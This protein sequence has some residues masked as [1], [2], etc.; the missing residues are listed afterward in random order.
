MGCSH[1]ICSRIYT[2]KKYT[3]NEWYSNCSPVPVGVLLYSYLHSKHPRY[4]IYALFCK[5]RS[6]IPGKSVQDEFEVHFY[7]RVQDGRIARSHK[8]NVNFHIHCDVSVGHRHLKKRGIYLRERNETSEL[9]KVGSMC[10]RFLPKIN[11]TS[12]IEDGSSCSEIYSKW[13]R[14]KFRSF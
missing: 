14:S 10:L 13:F 6:L 12:K 5:Q 1:H 3:I 8:D 2:V 7:S 11:K 9:R 4:P